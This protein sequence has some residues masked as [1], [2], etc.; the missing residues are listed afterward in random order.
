MIQLCYCGNFAIFKGVL[1]SALSV[2]KNTSEPIEILLCTMDL[3]EC[4]EKYIPFSDAQVKV[5]EGVIKKKNPQ[6][7]VTVL[8][9][10]EHYNT[11]L[12]G[13]NHE[14]M[15]TP[16]AAIRLLL[17][18]FETNDKVIYLD[19]DVM[20]LKDIREFYDVDIEN[21]EFGAVLDKMGHFWI[22][23]TYCNS[24]VLLL[25]MKKIRETKLFERCIDL[26][27]TK[28]MAFPDQS[29]LN[30]LAQNKLILPYKFN[31]QRKIKEDTVFKHFCKGFY[32]VRGIPW[33]YNY[34]Q[35]QIEKIH[36]LKIHE[37]DDVYAEYEAI[38]NSSEEKLV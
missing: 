34:K 15:Y 5:L 14:N 12:K 16:Y 7:C 24:G 4:N 36:K 1:L 30:D 20:C 29:A 26:I 25:N 19:T 10:T 9:M 13:K 27:K 23:K 32:F 6:S 8:D 11:Y 31:E 22:N 17:D 35:W 2:V 33:L 3:S 21:Y 18:K 38:V 28:K 37:F